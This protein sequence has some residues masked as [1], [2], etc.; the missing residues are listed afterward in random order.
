MLRRETASAHLQA[1]RGFDIKRRMGSMHDY[2][3][4]LG[5]LWR[6][7]LVTHRA[8][9]AAAWAGLP[10]AREVAEARLEWL[11]EDLAS[12]GIMPPATVLA[13]ALADEAEALG[14]LYVMEGS[15][16]G[17]LVLARLVQVRLGIGSATGARFLHGFAGETDAIWLEFVAELDRRP[18]AANGS[19]ALAGAMRTFDLFNA[20][21]AG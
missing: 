9:E 13:L 17:S 4:A 21:I 5:I 14:C 8:L 10:Q 11:R 1:E 7:H 3:C 15:M 19:G 2:G 18:L 20:A 12:L 16:L 6:L